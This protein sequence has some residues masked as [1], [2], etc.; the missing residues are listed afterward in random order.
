MSKGMAV[1]WHGPPGEPKVV[2]QVGAQ[3]KEPGRRGG[4]AAAATGS[5][6]SLAFIP[7][8]CGELK[9]LKAGLNEGQGQISDL[10]LA[11]APVCRG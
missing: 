4:A 2:L 6:K 5:S 1:K 3:R 10:K 11:L 8:Y 7:S 9:A